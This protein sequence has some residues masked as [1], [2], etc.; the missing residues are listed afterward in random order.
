MVTVA[1]FFYSQFDMK[2]RVLNLIFD[3][4][5]LFIKGSC[6]SLLK[7]IKMYFWEFEFKIIYLG[8]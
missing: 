7:F 5:C 8:I 3:Y 1:L 4:F 2:V 6:K